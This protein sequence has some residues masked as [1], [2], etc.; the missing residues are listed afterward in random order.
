MSLSTALVLLNSKAL[1]NLFGLTTRIIST[2]PIVSVIL[3]KEITPI[4]R[5]GL[6]SLIYIAIGGILAGLLGQVFYFAALKL[7]TKEGQ[8]SS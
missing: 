4:P 6:K 5:V 1:L 8:T 7:G 2:I 3:T